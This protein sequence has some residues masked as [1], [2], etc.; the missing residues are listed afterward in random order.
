VR[1]Y[2]PL[3]GKRILDVGCGL[4]LYV[5]AFRV[6]SADV[7]GVDVDPARVAQASEMLPNI[8]VGAAESLPYPDAY[9]DVVFSNEVLEHVDDD[10]AAVRESLRVCKPGGRLVAFVPNRWYPF[11]THGIYWRGR[12]HY[13]NMPLVNYLPDAIRRR[14]APHVRAYT[15]HGLRRLFAGLPGRIVVHRRVF[16]GYDN[17]VARWP[18]LGRALRAASYALE[19]T[20]LQVLGLSHLIVFE[21]TTPPA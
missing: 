15:G 5:Q 3:E 16:A 11:E 17:I 10:G 1:H 9:F 4:G 7:H 19:R 6:Y 8:R 12:Y 20:P 2:A 18:T 21:K 14:L 13:G